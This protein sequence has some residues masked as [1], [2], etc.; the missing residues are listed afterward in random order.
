MDMDINCEDSFSWLTPLV[1]ASRDTGKLIHD[2]QL[3]IT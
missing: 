1:S 3:I 2:V